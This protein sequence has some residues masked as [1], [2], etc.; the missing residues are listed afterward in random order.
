MNNW[1]DW[2]N[3]KNMCGILQW[4][5]CIIL[6]WFVKNTTAYHLD[7]YSL[8]SCS[9]LPWMCCI[10]LF[11]FVKNTTAYHLGR[12][13]LLLTSSMG[14]A[15]S[16]VPVSITPHHRG[17]YS[18]LLTFIITTKQNFVQSFRIFGLCRGTFRHRVLR[19]LHLRRCRLKYITFF[20]Y[21]N[22]VNHFQGF[23]RLATGLDIIKRFFR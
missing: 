17:Q 18:S 3:S 19:D 4:T 13:S 2:P 20:I 1:L 14:M 21:Q 12:Y 6:L 8:I 11:W 5:C 9:I 22:Q 7:S 23:I 15:S 10:I 16:M